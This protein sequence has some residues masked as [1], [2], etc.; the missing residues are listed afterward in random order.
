MKSSYDLLW[1]AARNPTRDPLTICNNLRRILENYFK[2]LGG[3]NTHSLYEKFEG[4]E[5]LICRALVS[6][7]N[8]GSHFA[9][10]DLHLS[11][12]GEVDKYLDVFRKVFEK[13][14][15][16]AHYKMMMGNAFV[17]RPEP[18]KS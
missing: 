9:M 10:E 14:N 6:W 2:L 11:P 18:L 7:I 8:D 4:D 17:P 12:G 16:E 5:Q 3:I 13:H 1:D 15:H